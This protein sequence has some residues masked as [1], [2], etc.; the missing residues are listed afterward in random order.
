MNNVQGPD[1]NVKAGTPFRRAIMKFRELAF[2]ESRPAGER[3]LIL[4]RIKPYKGRGKNHNYPFIAKAE[5]GC[6]PP[7]HGQRMRLIERN[8]YAKRVA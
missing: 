7:V 6:T 8:K 1:L 2:A 5:T 4:S 3:E